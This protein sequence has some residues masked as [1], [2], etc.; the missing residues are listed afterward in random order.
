MPDDPHQIRDEPPPIG[1]WP[2]VY[3]GILIYLTI[4]IGLFYAF[5]RAYA[6]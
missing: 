3:A 6:P 5:T 1:T 2:Q 4:V